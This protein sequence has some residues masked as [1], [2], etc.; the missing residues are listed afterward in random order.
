M[1]ELIPIR[2]ALPHTSYSGEHI[3]HLIR[4]K[5]VPGKKV[6]TIWLVDLDSLK[7][8]EQKMQELGKAKHR[9]KSLDEND[10]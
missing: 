8:Y 1:A 6:A 2:D 9:P 10:N 4:N 5:L 7:E 3:R